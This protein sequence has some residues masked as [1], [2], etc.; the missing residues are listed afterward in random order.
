MVIVGNELY[1]AA[2]DHHHMKDRCLAYHLA[3]RPLCFSSFTAHFSPM[4]S[5]PHCLSLSIMFLTT[6]V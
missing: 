4:L 5:L 3:W 6:L 1:G 2:N